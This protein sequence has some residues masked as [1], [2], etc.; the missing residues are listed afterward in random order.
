MTTDKTMIKSSHVVPKKRELNLK[1]AEKVVA[2]KK[3]TKADKVDQLLKTLTFLTGLTLDDIIKEVEGTDEAKA[4]AQLENIIK[5]SE[6]MNIPT[7][8]PG[9]L[10]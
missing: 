10:Y 7:G 6:H 1:K 9:D 4:K 5:M 2:K 3:P 8:L